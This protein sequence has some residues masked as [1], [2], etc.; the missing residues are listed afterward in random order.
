MPRVLSFVLSS[1]KPM[2]YLDDLKRWGFIKDSNFSSG[3]RF[4]HS[5]IP[6]SEVIRST[7]EDRVSSVAKNVIPSNCLGPL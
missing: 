2:A 5:L 6:Y 4:T 1:Y 3:K 7:S